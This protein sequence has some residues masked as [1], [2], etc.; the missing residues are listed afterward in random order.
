M[1]KPSGQNCPHSQS[2]C[3]PLHDDFWDFFLFLVRIP[4]GNVCTCI[5]WCSC[6]SVQDSRKYPDN[7]D[8][9]IIGLLNLP[10]YTSVLLSGGTKGKSKAGTRR[11]AQLPGKSQ[12]DALFSSMAKSWGNFSGWTCLGSCSWKRQEG[13]VWGCGVLSGKK[14]EGRGERTTS[15]QQK[16]YVNSVQYHACYYLQDH[17]GRGEFA[18][19]GNLCLYRLFL[20]SST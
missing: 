19:R 9:I 6:I 10:F 1:V 20:I 16:A 8:L 18:R 3:K 13:C 5:W 15:T 2:I 11:L 12:K 7:S 4:P 14:G 17:L